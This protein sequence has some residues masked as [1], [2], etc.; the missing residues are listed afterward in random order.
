[1]SSKFNLRIKTTQSRRSKANNKAEALVVQK[2]RERKA[3]QLEE[4]CRWCIEN[5]ARGYKA[6]STGLFP[7]IK[8]KATINN[9]LDNKVITGKE[10][11]YCSILTSEEEES[12]VRFV[13]NK[14]QCLQGINKAELTWFIL[15]VLKIRDHVNKTKKGGRSFKKLSDNAKKALANK[16]LVVGL[17]FFLSLWY[18]PCFADF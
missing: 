18:K 16:R 3:A 5:N 13:K 11:E 14:N 17:S 2:K 12:L 9:R 10:K 7:L 8:D 6:L 1:M 15:D 4:A